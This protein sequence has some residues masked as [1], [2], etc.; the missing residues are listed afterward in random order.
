MNEEKKSIE[1]VESDSEPE[2][3]IIEIPTEMKESK[4]RSRKKTQKM[5][6]LEDYNTI[7]KEYNDMVINNKNSKYSKTYYHSYKW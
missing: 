1:V 7:I 5:V 2:E 6:T 4:S 3:E